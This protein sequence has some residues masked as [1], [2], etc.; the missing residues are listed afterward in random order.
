MC[1]SHMSRHRCRCWLEIVLWIINRQCDWTVL[2]DNKCITLTKAK[3]NRKQN[4]WGHFIYE[5]IILRL[6]V[7]SVKNGLSRA[8]ECKMKWEKFNSTPPHT[9]SALTVNNRSDAATACSAD[10]NDRKQHSWTS[11]CDTNTEAGGGGEKWK[12]KRGKDGEI[13]KER[14]YCHCVNTIYMLITP[15]VC[16]WISL[17]IKD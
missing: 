2:K 8:G 5:P 6:A 4:W 3:E 17:H 1:H 16:V 12:R 11:K 15:L 9:H 10:K 13:K 14:T 7:Q